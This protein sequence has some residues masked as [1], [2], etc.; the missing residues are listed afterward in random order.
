METKYVIVMWPE[1]QT[2]LQ[3]DD[4]HLIDQENYPEYGSSAYL[5]PIDTA[6][7]FDIYDID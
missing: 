4:I 3:E 2:I 7:E 1:S 5:I 6:I